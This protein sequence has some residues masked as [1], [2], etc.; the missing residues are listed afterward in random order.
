MPDGNVKLVARQLCPPLLWS[1][2]RRCYRGLFPLPPT[3]PP[4]L[5]YRLIS[6]LEELDAEIAR[7]RRHEAEL[8][9]HDALLEVLTSFGFREPTDL[10]DDPHSPQ[11]R[12]AQMALWRRVSG[13]ADYSPDVCEQT[14]FDFESWLR[15]PFPYWTRSSTTVGEQLAAMGLLIRALAL[16]PGGSILEFGPGQGALTMQLALTGFCVTAVDVNPT[17][18]ELLRRQAQK[19]DVAVTAVCSGMLDYEPAQRFD[20]V[21]FYES[22]HHCSDHVAMIRRLDSLV[23]EGGAVV[24]GGEPIIDDFAVPW[25]L[26]LVGQSLMCIRT[27]GWLEL[28]FRTDYFLDLMDRHGWKVQRFP[29]F[30][31]PWQIVFVARRK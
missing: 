3:P 26:R 21:V 30:D 1:L 15:R 25:G 19:Y 12:E 9:S 10:P 7:A 4:R 22:F 31:M 16:K 27:H 20:R 23:A 13:R 6:S 2:A 18:V 8:N 17:Y 5:P 14:D 24:F 28:G 29:S 11:Y